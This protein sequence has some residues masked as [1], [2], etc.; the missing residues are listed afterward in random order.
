MAER[1]DDHMSL[2]YYVWTDGYNTRKY[3][4]KFQLCSYKCVWLDFMIG[5]IKLNKSSYLGNNLKKY[6]LCLLAKSEVIN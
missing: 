4:N 5:A 6:S 2:N 3:F 1:T